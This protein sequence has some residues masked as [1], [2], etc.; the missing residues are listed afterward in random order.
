[1][2][3]KENSGDY[4]LL[5]IIPCPLRAGWR[6]WFSFP[7]A[8]FLLGDAYL[9]LVFCS[10]F[11]SRG[12]DVTLKNKEGETP[13]QCSSL[14]SQVWVALQMN[15][16]LKESSAD[17]PAQI[18]KVVSRWEIWLALLVG[19]EIEPLHGGGWGPGLRKEY[20]CM[21]NFLNWCEGQLELSKN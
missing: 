2:L 1:M 5:Q 6:M 7:L 17:K 9:F 21:L 3:N 15:K 16:T 14:N 10:L 11:L 8:Q 19:H 18:E 13:L 4:S 12:S 20:K